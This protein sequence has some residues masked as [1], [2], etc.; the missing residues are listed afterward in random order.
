MKVP[1]A[2]VDHDERLFALTAVVSHH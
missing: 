2:I 1:T